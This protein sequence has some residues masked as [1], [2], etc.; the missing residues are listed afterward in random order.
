MALRL[1]VGILVERGTI[2]ESF[3]PLVVDKLHLPDLAKADVTIPRC[4]ALLAGVGSF[5]INSWLAVIMLAVFV[6]GFT[7]LD[8]MALLI[9]AT[10]SGSRSRHAFAISKKLNKLAMLDVAS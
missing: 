8:M 5:D 9:A 3:V 6:L 1:D 10:C 4:I 7:V 2:P